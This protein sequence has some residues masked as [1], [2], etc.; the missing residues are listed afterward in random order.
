MRN[1]EKKSRENFNNKIGKRKSI[2]IV[3]VLLKEYH[4]MERKS[5]DY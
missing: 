2:K 3:I 1:Y 5:D 4:L